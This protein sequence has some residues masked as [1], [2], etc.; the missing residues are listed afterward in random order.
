MSKSDAVNIKQ[1]ISN[2]DYSASTYMVKEFHSQKNYLVLD[3]KDSYIGDLIKLYFSDSQ[4]F[5]TIKNHRLGY[6]IGRRAAW[7]KYF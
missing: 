6:L 1:T 2:T 3:A 4:Y 5:G 7:K